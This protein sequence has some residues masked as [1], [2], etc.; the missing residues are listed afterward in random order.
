MTPPFDIGPPSG[1]LDNMGNPMLGGPPHGHG[2]GPPG[3]MQQQQQMG[4]GP[5]QRG[6]FDPI[7]SMAAMT[8]HSPNSG[9]NPNM[10]PPGMNMTAMQV[11]GNGPGGGPPGPGQQNMV[12]FHTQMSSMHSIHQNQMNS[13][14]NPNGNP[15]MHGPNGPQFGMNQ[16][17]PNM[18]GGAQTVNNTYVNANLQIQQLNVQNMPP[19]FNPNMP[20]NSQG[21]CMPNQMGNNMHPNQMMPHPSMSPKLGQNPGGGPPGMGGPRMSSPSPQNC[22]F[23]GQP[24]G[25]GPRGMPMNNFQMGNNGMPGGGRGGP[26]FNSPNIQ[27]KPDAPNTIQYLPNRGANPTPRSKNPPAPNLDFLQHTIPLTN[28]DKK[29]PSQNLQYFPNSGGNMPPSNGPNMNPGPPPGNMP[30]NVGPGRPQLMMR[31]PQGPQNHMGQM[32]PGGPHNHMMQ[33]GDMMYNRPPGPQNMGPGGPGMYGPGP[34]GGM[35]G[36]P[37]GMNAGNGCPP[38]NMHMDGGPPQM[39]PNYNH[40]KQQGPPQQQNYMNPNMGPDPNYDRQYLNF[41]QQLYATNSRGNP[42]GENGSCANNQVHNNI[43]GAPNFYGQSK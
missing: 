34:P 35:N 14:P 10:M 37:G 2:P 17:P 21:M 33:S 7:A 29:V 43:G 3:H 22:P 8:E 9:M 18:V 38:P 5:N 6:P 26:G 25:P 1:K 36:P 40:F 41:Q 13:G 31:G 42:G 4:P 16:G 19:N 11:G 32:G 27:V 30:M 20:P 12:N 28:L 39:G 23:P 24:G 15:G